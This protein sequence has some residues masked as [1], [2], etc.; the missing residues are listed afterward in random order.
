MRMLGFKKN[1]KGMS[2]VELLVAM[3]IFAAAIVPMLYAFVYSTGYNFKSQQ[4]LQATGISQAIIENCKAANTN[5][6]T[7]TADLLSGDILTEN[8]SFSVDSVSDLGAGVYFFEGVRATNYDRTAVNDLVDAGNVNRR[9][10]DVRVKLTSIGDSVTDFSVMH[11]MRSGITANY[12]L[13]DVLKAQDQAAQG[14]IFNRLKDTVRA[15]VTVAESGLTPAQIESNANNFFVNALDIRNVYIVRKIT[16]TAMD[17]GVKVKVEYFYDGYGNDASHPVTFTRS[18]TNNISGSTYHFSVNVSI[19]TDPDPADATGNYEYD[20]LVGAPASSVFFYYYPCYK[21]TNGIDGVYGGSDDTCNFKDS[22]V[23]QNDMSSAY[24]INGTEDSNRLDFY[25]FKQN[26][27]TG[28]RYA[29][30]KIEDYEVDYECEV[31]L[32]NNSSFPVNLY[33]NFLWNCATG[34]DLPAAAVPT[35]LDGGNTYNRTRVVHADPDNLSDRGIL[36]PLVT[37]YYKDTFYNDEPGGDRNSLILEDQAV[38]PYWSEK[39]DGVSSVTYYGARYGVLIQV[40]PHGS[41]TE[42]E[43]MYSEFL[44][45]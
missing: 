41:S 19:P 42:I 10:Y 29:D 12:T 15:N 9:A 39:Y 16:I 35:V 11:P 23:L 31:E 24:L 25:L 13:A 22:F 17:S 3:A 33:H 2:L 21:A 18:A 27:T 37:D 44:N 36:N 40:Y 34:A 28:D 1:N 7:I 30:D 4:T 32:I 8:N 43:S 38:F 45:W 26:D 6:D 20:A 14:V 5:Y